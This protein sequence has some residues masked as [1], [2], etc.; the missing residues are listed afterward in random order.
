M[1]ILKAL[2]KE[3][4]D[5][6]P[7]WYMRQAGRYLPEYLQLKGSDSFLELAMN[8]KKAIEISI[9]PYKRFRMD[10]IILF[11]DILTPLQAVGIPIEF[12]EKIGPTLKYDVFNKDD[13]KKIKNFEPEKQVFYVRE[14]IQGIKNY[15]KNIN[16]DN[17]ALIGFSG[18]PFTLLSY[19]VEG[20]TA[21]KF[22]K[23]KEFMF[24]FEKDFHHLMEDITNLIIEYLKFQIQSGVDLVQIFD[25]WGGILSYHHYEEFCFPYLKK[26]IKNIKQYVPV[27]LFVGNNAHLVKLLSLLEPD[28]ISLDWRVEDITMIPENIAIQGNMDPLVLF[29]SSERVKKETLNILNKFSKRKN[30]IFNLGHGIYPNTPL[31]NV[32]VMVQTIKE[33]RLNE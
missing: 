14:I 22:E 17:V 30:F 20:G 32:E 8:P 11:A 13:L 21:K 18:A 3:P 16:D 29:G 28:C 1:R 9:Q 19:L 7:F 26:I 5:R 10:A 27:I 31:H 15:I 33:Y 2:K 25:S 6:I 12:H 23:T 4:I 24:N